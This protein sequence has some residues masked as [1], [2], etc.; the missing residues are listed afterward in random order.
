MTRR[1]DRCAQVT[2][3][4]VWHALRGKSMTRPQR[5]NQSELSE[6]E[7]LHTKPQKKKTLHGHQDYVAT[8]NDNDELD[9]HANT[10]S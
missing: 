7:S 1:G 5:Q 10:Q 6:P 2:E 3:G 9:H 4:R 8:D